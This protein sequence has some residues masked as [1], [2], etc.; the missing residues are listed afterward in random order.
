MPKVRTSQSSMI[1][2]C[3]SYASWNYVAKE[4]WDGAR[5]HLWKLRLWTLRLPAPHANTAPSSPLEG[6]AKR[7]QCAA[8]ICRKWKT[9][10]MHCSVLRPCLFLVLKTI[11]MSKVLACIFTSL[12]TCWFGIWNEALAWVQAQV[13][14]KRLYQG[15]PVPF[16]NTS[17]YLGFRDTRHQQHTDLPSQDGIIDKDVTQVSERML[18]TL[19]ADTINLYSLDDK[20]TGERR[21]LICQSFPVEGILDQSVV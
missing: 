6:L 21:G 15:Q 11:N 9:P 3:M 2:C 16:P 8:R 20:I 10:Q 18:A 17:C 19:T 14:A 5:K 7:R 12:S 13:T 4:P 1:M